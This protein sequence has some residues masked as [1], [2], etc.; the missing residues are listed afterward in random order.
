MNANNKKW[1]NYLIN[2]DR[3][4]VY[5]FILL[6][7]TL[8]FFLK[9]VVN[10][11][12]TKW[13][14][15]AYNLIEEAAKVNKPIMIGFDY[16]PSTMAEL[17]P[18]ARTILRHAFSK[19]V[20]IMG[21]NFMPNGTALGALTMD[22]IAKEYGKI[23]GTDYVYMPYMPQYSLVLIN[24]G[25]DLR[26][27]Y[28]KDYRGTLIEDIPMLKGVKNYDDFHLV[29]D[30]SGTK[31][32][33]M[34][35]TFGVTKYNFNFV[36]GTTAV[37]ATEYYT[38]LQ[39]GQMKG[40]LPGMKGAAEYEFISGKIAEAMRGMASQEWGHLIIILFI[41]VGNILYFVNRKINNQE[42]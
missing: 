40:L 15:E 10:I 5:V 23:N 33:Q 7:V 16:D 29:I 1:I 6:A 8:P 26:L 14:Q 31:L 24:L 41:I 19:N 13:V 28:A 34:Y 20:K 35:I 11:K 12:T 42:N 18:M 3:R 32:P 30:L 39:S 4:V 36:V 17:D 27:Q 21:I 25:N 2:I 37:S 9:P 38:Y 22:E